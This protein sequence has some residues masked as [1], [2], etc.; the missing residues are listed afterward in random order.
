MSAVTYR[1]GVAIITTPTK[2]TTVHLTAMSRSIMDGFVDRS[3]AVTRALACGYLAVEAER[4]ALH[5]ELKAARAG[6]IGREHATEMQNARAALANLRQA[7][8]LFLEV[9]DRGDAPD[10]DV[11]EKLRDA[12]ADAEGWLIHDCN[13]ASARAKVLKGG[14]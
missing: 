12:M 8:Q 11:D 4:D 13:A 14:A 7:G 5:E 10:G 2:F 9:Y 1:D 3:S 6:E